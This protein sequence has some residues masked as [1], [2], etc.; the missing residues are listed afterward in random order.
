MEGHHFVGILDDGKLDRK[1]LALCGRVSVSC[2]GKP[3]SCA[4]LPKFEQYEN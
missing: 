4:E 1:A 2:V 3:K